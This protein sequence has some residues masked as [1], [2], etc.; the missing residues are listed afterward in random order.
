MSRA[1]GPVPLVFALA[2]FSGTTGMTSS[3]ASA[4]PAPYT[5]TITGVDDDGLRG[6]LN[7]TS[8][9]VQ[10]QGEPA[11]GLIG[12]RRRADGDHER[13][14]A[15]LQSEGYYDAHL[16]IALGSR[17]AGSTPPPTTVV[18]IT[19][20][21][22]LP[23]RFHHT[24]VIAPPGNLLPTFDS[25]TLGLTPGAVARA[26]LVVAAEQRLRD[27][28]AGFGF[29]FANVTK[30]RAEI[31]REAKAMD[32]TFIVT[33]G[34]VVRLGAIHVVGLDQV[35]ESLV[36]QQAA[37]IPGE[38]Y[39]P[40]LFERTRASL[41]K[42]GV[43]GSISLHLAEQP[44][45]DGTHAV[46]ITVTE[47]KR[48]YIGLGVTFTNAEGLGAQA[49]WGHRNLFG[50]G[51]QLRLGAELDRL[52]IR[53]LT[54]AGLDQADEK[55]TAD[56]RKPDFLAPSQ[57]LTVSTAAINEHPEAYQRQALTAG[58]QLERRLPD[59]LTLGYGLSGEQSEIT[60]TTGFTS[61][62][63]AGSP[64][65][66]RYDTTDAILNPTTGYRLAVETTPWLRLGDTG[67]SFVINRI[68]QSA[69]QDLAGDGE[70]VAAG[71]LSVGSILNGTA[72][73]LPADKRFYAGGGGSVRGYAYQK[74][75]P[76]D[77][78][79]H[80]LGGQSLAEASAEVR[81]KITDTLGVV[82]FLDGGNVYSSLLPQP[83]QALRFGTG[84]GFRYYTGFGPL[85]L[86]LGTPLQP[87]QTDQPIQVYLS[88]GQ[89]F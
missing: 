7:A 47:R 34:P 82:P 86:D 74:V 19:I 67:Q 23:Y 35:D 60:D 41:S 84:L 29:A 63:L 24:T 51:E 2:L 45:A 66:L 43:F 11:P 87:T 56:L 76:L 81:I 30:R 39:R 52:N 64:L 27:R 71:R 22:G 50:G 18:T 14:D 61:A 55:L 72:A 88:M 44:D 57:D 1:L 77:A 83:G 38:L 12:L 75:G 37:W 15:V 49:S 20:T 89:A 62:T 16:D 85:R 79:G 6:L 68:T 13:L 78:T 48:R 58:F 46:T 8:V 54:P 25:G 5:V 31:D 3:P 65:S 80:P 33:T 32:V 9:L 10:L 42:L 70:W 26:P 17:N 28:L 73:D 4:Q 36:R 40:E 53:T 21:T 59:H 69:Y